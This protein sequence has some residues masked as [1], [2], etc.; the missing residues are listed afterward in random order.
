MKKKI[1]PVVILVI[2]GIIWFVLANKFEDK[3]HSTYLPVLQEK[4]D[5]GLIE[6]AM[7][8]IKIHKY[9]FT[10]IVENIAIF[11]KSD[12]FQ[13]KLD[14]ISVFYKFKII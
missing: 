11:P 3:I 8:D 12:F 6:L 14:K 4:K 5:S 2:V 1:L 9:K 10:V 7:D 13:A